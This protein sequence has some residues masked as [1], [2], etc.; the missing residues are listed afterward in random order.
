MQ[1]RHSP[2]LPAPPLP[3][4]PLPPPP[5]PTPPRVSRPLPEIPVRDVTVSETREL[6]PTIPVVRHEALRPPLGPRK[7]P[8]PPSSLSSHVRAPSNDYPSTLASSYTPARSTPPPTVCS[9]KYPDSA[10]RTGY[11]TIKLEPPRRDVSPERLRPKIEVS[12]PIIPQNLK[13]RTLRRALARGLRR[14]GL[15]VLSAFLCR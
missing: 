2:P 11:G 6:K 1:S 8:T 3:S 9:E 5:L 14:I 13:P 7:L 4:P 10:S 12:P 15:L